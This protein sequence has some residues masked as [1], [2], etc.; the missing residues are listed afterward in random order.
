MKN[1][2]QHIQEAQ[3]TPNRINE[4]KSDWVASRHTGKHLSMYI[5]NQS[6]TKEKKVN[7]ENKKKS[8][9]HKQGPSR[10]LTVNITPEFMKARSQWHDIFKEL[11]EKDYQPR[12]LYSAKLSF[13][14]KEKFRHSQIKKNIF[15]F[16]SRPDLMKEH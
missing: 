11:K 13:I 3:Q 4:K 9:H 12:I 8:T 15:F 14:K 6:K 7:L 1:I 2:Y 10:R 5:V 16:A